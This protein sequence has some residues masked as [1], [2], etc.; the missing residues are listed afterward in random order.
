MAGIRINM[1]VIQVA[2]VEGV[3]RRAAVVEDILEVVVA[4]NGAANLE[5]AAVAGR[6]TLVRIKK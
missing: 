5:W 2:V 6:L 4:D 3:Y 1:F